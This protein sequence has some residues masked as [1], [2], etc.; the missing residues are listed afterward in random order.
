[1]YMYTH[2]RLAAYHLKTLCVRHLEIM[3]SSQK[4]SLASIAEWI[5]ILKIEISEQA[6]IDIDR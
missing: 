4:T 2:L 3:K 1:M 5:D 6:N